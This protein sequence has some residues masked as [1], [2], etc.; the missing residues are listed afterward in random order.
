MF[1]VNQKKQNLIPI[2]IGVLALLG[3]T[4]IYGIYAVNSNTAQQK[5]DELITTETFELKAVTALGRIEPEGEAIQLSPSPDL[6]G[7]KINQLLVREGDR[8]AKGQKIAIL[9]NNARSQA[10]LEL[11]KQDV[12]V[13]EANLAIVKAGAKSGEIKAQEATVKRIQAELR[14]E[15]IANEALIARLEAQL[16]T[17]TAEKQAT[18]ERL[19]AEL[20]KAESDLRRYT[21]LEADGVIS[22]SELESRSLNVDTAAKRLVEAQAGYNR[23][24]DTLAQQIKEAKAISQQE[25]DTLEEQITEAEATLDRIAEVREVDV[26]KAQAEVDRAIAALKKAEEDLALTYVTAP[27][28]GQIMTI[29]TYPGEIVGDDGVVEFG[30]TNQMIVVAEVYESDINRVQMGQKATILSETG[31]FDQELTGTVSHIGLKIGKQDVLDNDP[32]ADVDSR[33]VEVEIRLDSASSDRVSA[34]TNS[35]ALVKIEVNNDSSK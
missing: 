4:T 25:I 2:S 28:D 6:G 24:L 1:F 21:K 12:K 27:T 20:A 30:Q 14:G 3:G 29:H 26:L 31:A 17:E 32:A 13:A 10:D 15:I 16:R 9:D 34:L 23:T 5:V 8:V 18:I 7:T 22:E 19:E 11:A 35:K 33:V